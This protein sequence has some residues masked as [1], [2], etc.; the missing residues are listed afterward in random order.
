[1]TNLIN[2]RK[3]FDALAS[4]WINDEE[5]HYLEYCEDI[6]ANDKY[7][8][9]DYQKVCVDNIK[10]ITDKEIKTLKKFNIAY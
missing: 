10:P 4:N 3:E 9:C 2:V 7:K 6:L 5:K 8:N 1:M